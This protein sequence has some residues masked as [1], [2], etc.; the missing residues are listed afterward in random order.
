M[1]LHAVRTSIMIIA[2]VTS[3]EIFCDR[4]I[5]MILSFNCFNFFLQ[6]KLVNFS[7]MAHGSVQK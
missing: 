2:N 3:T 6:F 1:A 4:E 7:V 5:L